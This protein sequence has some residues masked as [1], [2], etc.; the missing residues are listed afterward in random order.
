MEFIEALRDKLEQSEQRSLALDIDETLSLT[1]ISWTEVILEKFGNPE[2]LTAKEVVDKYRYTTQIPHIIGLPEFQAWHSEYVVSNAAYENLRPIEQ[3]VE[4]VKIIHRHMPIAAY[5]TTRPEVVNIGTQLWLDKHG[6][7]KAVIIG[8]PESVSHKDG[9][10]WKAS[11]LN[12]LYPYIEGIV[13]DNP[14]LA[15]SLP[16]DYKGSLYLYNSTKSPRNDSVKVIPCP[17]WHDVH[18][19]ILSK[20]KTRHFAKS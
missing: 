3:A 7:P 10:I 6:F 13:D 18:N 1:T 8:R 19:A 2:R 20:Y 4:L 15:M 16:A 12:R 9:N 17:S 14:G 11:V 5:I